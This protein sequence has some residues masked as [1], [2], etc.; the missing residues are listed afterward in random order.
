MGNSGQ[1]WPLF[2]SLVFG[3]WSLAFAP[4]G[5]SVQAQV[6]KTKDQR[7]KSKVQVAIQ[8][9]RAKLLK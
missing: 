8:R 3:L 1:R 6:Q 9:R 4:A 7:P 2:L 5:F